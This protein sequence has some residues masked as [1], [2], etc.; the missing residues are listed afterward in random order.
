[1]LAGVAVVGLIG[2]AGV[3]WAGIGTDE[4][5][6]HA[7]STDSRAQVETVPPSAPTGRPTG[8]VAPTAA[9][10]DWLATLDRLDAVR[11]R[12]FA[13]RRPALLSRVYAPGPLLAGDAASL[14]R[15][16]PPGCVLRGAHTSFG[17]A[18]VVGHR[19]HA[20]ITASA[21]MA[22][23]RLTCPGRAAQTAPGATARLRIVL[24]STPDGV[25][26]VA[27]RVLR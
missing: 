25:R 19:D 18:G 3:A 16:V 22:P 20:V 6:V 7:I 13:A 10:R 15:L 4:S 2:C 21:S 1:V 8:P 24:R 11:A 9:H 12:A 23:S 14:T 5:R 17:H 26:I 27:E